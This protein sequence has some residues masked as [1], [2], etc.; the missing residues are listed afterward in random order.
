[1]FYALTKETPLLIKETVGG[2]ASNL[3]KMIC[4]DQPVPPAFVASVEECFKLDFS[5]EIHSPG[6]LFDLE[7]RSH[8]RWL[9][10]VTD[11]VW[12]S[13]ITP[14]LVSVRSGAPVSMPGMME[15]VLN[16][17]LTRNN[18]EGFATSRK[19]TDLFAY[20]CY[21][22]L[23]QMYGTTV[24][25]I[26]PEKFNE[27]YKAS[28]I[29]YSGLSEYSACK[30]VDLYE[31]IYE[32]ETG[33]S[34]PD[35]P[36]EQLL[37]ACNAVFKSWH[38]DKAIAYRDLE[39]ID[40]N[41]GTAVTVQAMVFGNIDDRSATGVVFTHDPN[42]GALGWYGDFLLNAQGED[43]VSGNHNVSPI[44]EI[45][46]HKTL[47]QVGKELQR[48]VGEL[49][50]HHRDIMDIEFTVESG[51]LWIL[52]YRRAKCSRL[53]TVRC[54]LDMARAGLIQPTEATQRIMELLPSTSTGSVDP[55]NLTL[56]GK[57]LGA[58]NGEVVGVIA[59]GKET[60]DK[61]RA[62]NVDYV[63]VATETAPDDVP[64]M[65]GAVGILTASGGLVSHAALIAR[66]WDKTCVLGFEQIKVESDHFVHNGEVYINGSLI[67]IN[68]S[69]GEVYA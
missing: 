27:I 65:K 11:Y 30:L 12:A 9:A 48:K 57:G 56:L 58:T 32:K 10:S 59:I 60:A 28:R 35:D 19:S 26:D 4:D 31:A 18:L 5:R 43:V 8:I 68:G 55:G 53:A 66:G 44:N 25:R 46:D 34:F 21:R 15:T 24:D 41:M 63:Y 38:G 37:G 22:R 49:Y 6:S 69:T 62:E 13:D 3:H 1:M 16:V 61:F 42:S 20:D 7:L 29:F 39:G 64:Q 51:K 67:K 52:Q 36:N 50:K 23:I 47:G 54:T 14:L 2:K 17:G 45:L 33:R 40:H